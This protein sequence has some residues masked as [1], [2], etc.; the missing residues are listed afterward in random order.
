MKDF[1][2]LFKDLK[3]TPGEVIR[4]H[5]KNFH[6]TLKELAQATG[7]AESNLSLI[8]NDKIEIGLRRAVLIAAA[9]GISPS[10]ILFPPGYESSYSKETEKVHKRASKLFLS[11]RKK[12]ISEEAA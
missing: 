10:S 6:I 4:A 5:R 7:V 8:E 11:K 3:A 1:L 9:L 2:E 12:L